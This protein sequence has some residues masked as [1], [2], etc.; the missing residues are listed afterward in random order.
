MYWTVIFLFLGGCASM[1]TITPSGLGKIQLGMKMPVAGAGRY[2]GHGMRDSICNE[3]EYQWRVAILHYPKGNVW[4]EEDFFGGNIINR[5][6]VETPD[7]K[8]RNGM[9][10]GIPVSRLLESTEVWYI[11]PLPL[12]RKF[13]FYSPVFQGI[14][15]IVDDPSRVIDSERFEDY[16]VSSFDSVAKVVAIVVF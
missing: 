15:F 7:V 10:V 4:I 8:L 5:I 12:Y 14:H 1:H 9:V 11:N 13:D 16:P 2:K 3:N 6:R